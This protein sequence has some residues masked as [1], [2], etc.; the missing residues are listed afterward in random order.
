MHNARTRI[1]WG[2]Q[3]IQV[4]SR[5]LQYFLEAELNASLS[6]LRNVVLRS[7]IKKLNEM[8]K[9]NVNLAIHCIVTLI[10]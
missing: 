5:S 3:K 9:I 1:H 2:G 7:I 6:E 8:V 10:L 4:E